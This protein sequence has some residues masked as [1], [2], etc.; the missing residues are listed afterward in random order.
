MN[1]SYFVCPV[2]FGQ[3]NMLHVPFVGITSI[4]FITHPCP[5]NR[6]LRIVALS[7]STRPVSGDAI[8]GIIVSPYGNS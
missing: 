2:V 3:E 5:K 6:L 4:G 8:R 7:M 1:K